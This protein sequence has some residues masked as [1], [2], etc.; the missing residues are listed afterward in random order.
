[1]IATN[2]AAF[3]LLRIA[4]AVTHLVIRLSISY[5]L[6]GLDW[7]LP[8]SAGCCC[9][10]LQEL[11]L[12]VESCNY[13][14]VQAIVNRRPQR[15]Q[16]L[17]IAREMAGNIAPSGAQSKDEVAEMVERM[18]RDGRVSVVEDDLIPGYEVEMERMR[19]CIC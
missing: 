10:L 15:L 14:H 3:Q 7:F 16:K 17:L 2:V 6:R 11:S 8:S 4:P 18:V 1:M 12:Y 13:H 9:P 19:Q 5:L